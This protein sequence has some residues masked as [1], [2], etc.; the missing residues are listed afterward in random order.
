[1]LHCTYL[2]TAN[3]FDIPSHFISCAPLPLPFA[4]KPRRG[5]GDAAGACPLLF[6]CREWVHGADELLRVVPGLVTETASTQQ[7]T[8]YNLDNQLVRRRAR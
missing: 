3:T 5:L 2:P 4:V 7:L 1:M 8:L 6:I